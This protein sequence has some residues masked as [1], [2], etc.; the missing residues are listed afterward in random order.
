MTAFWCLQV[1]GGH[2]PGGQPHRRQPACSTMSSYQRLG[3]RGTG[4]ERVPQFHD[5]ARKTLQLALARSFHPHVATR[6]H[7]FGSPGPWSNEPGVEPCLQARVEAP[8]GAVTCPIQTAP[9]MAT[10]GPHGWLNQPQR[11]DGTIQRPFRECAPS[12]GSQLLEIAQALHAFA[13]SFNVP[14]TTREAQDDLSREH[15]R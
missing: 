3:G 9:R 6:W 4:I 8:P 1:N 11:Q 10:W 15:L 2:S 13:C 5:P 7:R 12:L 14:S